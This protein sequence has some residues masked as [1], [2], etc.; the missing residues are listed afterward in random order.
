MPDES[1]Q[2]TF[3]DWADADYEKLRKAITRSG[4]PLQGMVVDKLLKNLPSEASHQ[5]IEIQE[6]WS[7]VDRETEAIRQI[8]A[9]VGYQVSET[10]QDRDDFHD[11][12][13]WIRVHLNFLVECK[14]SDLP[15][16][17]FTRE[18]AGHCSIPLMFGH[19]HEDIELRDDPTAEGIIQMSAS[20]A[21]GIWDLGIPNPVRAMSIAKAHRKGKSLELSGEDCYRSIALP[22]LKALEHLKDITRPGHQRMYYDVRLV[23]PIAVLRAPL[24][25]AEVIEGDVRIKPVSH[26]RLLRSEPGPESLGGFESTGF[27]IVNY[28]YLDSYVDAARKAASIL[29][30]RIKSFSTQMLTGIAVFDPT[31]SELSRKYPYASMKA[32]V[33]IDEMAESLRARFREVHS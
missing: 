18:T 19:P 12:S 24:I 10:Q 31:S 23:F 6:E 9:L 5:R 13:S 20:D 29:A 25:S 11:P 28:D 30:E 4:Y 22:V 32:H 33:G 17:V 14:Q 3:T 27:D 2:E 8:D 7:F 21:L 26:V 15:F 16:V 1:P